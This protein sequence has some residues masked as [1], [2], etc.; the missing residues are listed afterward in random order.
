MELEKEELKRQ[1][2][3]H[4]HINLH[5]LD[6]VYM[7]CAM[8]LEI[9]NIA[10]NQYSVTKKVVS[11][12]FK[13]LIDAYDSKAFYLAAENY[14][15]SLVLAAKQLNKSNWRAAIDHIFEIKL[16]QKM[17]EFSAEGGCRQTLVG[18]FKEAA[19]RAFLCRGA[20]TYASFS[21]AHLAQQFELPEEAVHQVVAKMIIKNKVQA[22]FDTGRQLVVMDTA[23]SEAKELQQLALQ[24]VERLEGMVENNERLI[25]M[26]QGGALYQYK[27]RTQGEINALNAS[28]KQKQL[29]KAAAGVP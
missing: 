26:L 4:M 23:S 22:H 10:E 6:C 9:P 25:D 3:F 14:R 20:R 5:Q 15:D 16:V 24:Y 8:L 7:I 1:V 12:N 18:R 19:L 11:K 28:K 2:P 13:K 17:P 27:E 21:V 29:L